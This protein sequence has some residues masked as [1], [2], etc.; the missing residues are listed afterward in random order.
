[1][2]TNRRNAL[3]IGG[4]LLFLFIGFRPPEGKSKF[5]TANIQFE[6]QQAP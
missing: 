4:L 6:A 1:M 5:P 2:N 3:I